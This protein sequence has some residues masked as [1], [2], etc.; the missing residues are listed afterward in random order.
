[1]AI[2]TIRVFAEYTS[3]GYVPMPSQG[4]IDYG[5]T[6][7]STFPETQPS[8]FQTDDPNIDVA[9]TTMTDFYVWIRT[10]GSAWNPNYTRVVRVYPDS[11]SINSVVM[12]MIVAVGG[13]GTTISSGGGV[14]YYLNGGTSQ[15]ILDGST[16]YEMN[17]VPVQGTGVDFFKINTTGFQNIAQFVTDAGDPGLLNIPAGNWPLGLYMSASD[18]SGAPKFYAEIYKYSAAGVFTLLGS[19]VA[20][21]EVISNGQA[22]DYYTSTVAIPETT[23]LV[24]DRIA[25]RIFVNTDGNRTINLHTQDSHLSTV[26]TTF[27]RGLTAI[28]GLIK[29]VQFLAIGNAGSDAAIVSSDDTHTINLPTASATKRG[30]LNSTDWSTFNAKQPALSGDGFVKISGSTISYDNSSYQPLDGDLTAIGALAGT[31]GILKKTGANT[32]EL[33]TSVYLSTATAASTYQRLDKMVSNLLPSDTEYPNSN[34]VLAKLALKA[35][36]ANPSFTGSMNISGAESRVNFYDENAARKY[37]IGYDGGFLRIYQDAGSTSR[38]YINS[39]GKTFIPGTLEVG[40]IIKTGGL[41]TEFLKA[42]GTVDSNT[43]ALNSALANYL[44]SATAGTTYQ[45]LANLSTDLTA[46]TTKYPSVTAVNTG[47][48]TKQPLDAD[49]TAIAALTGTSGLLKKTAADTWTLDTAAYITSSALTNYLLSSDAA[50]TYQRKDKMVSNLLASDTEYPNSN[51]VIAALALKANAANPTFTGDFTIS[52]VTPRLYFVDT[53]NNP[54][55][56]LFTDSGYFY[57]Y[58]QTAGATRFSINSSGYATFNKRVTFQ[59]TVDERPQLPGGF[60]GIDTGD[61]NFD[62]WGISRDYYPSNATAANAWGIRWNGTNND[63]EFVGAGV[64]RAIIDLDN[65]NITSL[66][67]ITASNLSGTNT[68]DQTNIAGYSNELYS[69]DLRTISPSSH[70][71]YRATF[72]FTSWNNNSTGDWADYLHLRSYQDASG[73]ADNLVMFKKNGIAMRIWQQSWGSA[74]AYSSYADVLH[75]SNYSSYALP[76]GGGTMTGQILSPSMTDSVYGGAF[77][78]RERGFVSSAQSAWSYSPAITFHWGNRSVIRMGLRSDGYMAIDDNII[79]TTANVET[80]A[81]LN[82]SRTNWEVGNSVINNVVGQLAWKNY[83]NNHTIFDASNGTSPNGTAVNATNSQVAWSS[84]YPTLMGWNGSNTYGV[85]VDSARVADSSGNS[86]T[87]SQRD[88]SGDIST[89]GQGRFTGWYNGNAATTLGAEIGVSSGRAYVIAYN[90]AA[91]AYGDIQME[92]NYVALKTVNNS[93]VEILTYN[94]YKVNFTGGDQIN[95]Y[96]GSAATTMYLNYSGGNGAGINMAAGRFTLDTAGNAISTGSMRSPIFYDSNDTSYYLDPNSSS[97]A[98]RIAGNIFSDGSFGTNGSSAL[99]TTTVGRTFSPKGGAYSF[100]GGSI[101]GAIKIRLPFRANDAMWSMTVRIYNYSTNQTCEYL[102]GN[103][104]YSQGSWNPSASCY[105]GSSTALQTVRFGN[106]GGYDCVW[107]GET[108]TVWSYPVVSVMDFTSGYSN[109]NV[110]NYMSGWDVNIVSSFGTV[111]GAIGASIKFGDIT[112]TF[113]DSKNGYRSQSNPWGTA[114]SAYFPNGI[115]TAGGTNWI[116]GYTYIGNAPSNGSGHEFFA[117]GN[118][119][120]TGIYTFGL[121]S[122]TDSGIAIN[123]S[124]TGYGRIR[125]YGSGTNYATIHA[126]GTS[127]GYTPSVGCLNI[128]ASGGVTLGGWNDP[129]LSVKSSA[130]T[131]RNKIIVGTFPQSQSNSGEAWLGRAA[132]RSTGIMTVQLGGGSSGSRFE[133]VDWAWSVVLFKAEGNGNVTASGS[134]Y[135]TAFYESSDSRLKTLLQDDIKVKNIE[136]LKAKLYIKNGKK[137]YGYFAQEAQSY[138]PSAVTTNEEGYLNLSYRE[139]HTAKIARLEQRVA[140]LEKQLKLA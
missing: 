9:V 45:T 128:D 11:P 94:N 17:K 98:L 129:Y 115:T 39:S 112:S 81:V 97:T 24:T 79:V 64:N 63:I 57:I 4:N 93:N 7:G 76:L 53:D 140:E 15:G 14:S 65:G 120:T 125:F 87:T 47:L 96:N 86:S 99:S 71:A 113:A 89:G 1:M 10:H 25:I 8:S 130:V 50:T 122:Q 21:P 12:N 48:A 16:Y 73:G 83:G 38:F 67:S 111:A 91:G 32:W 19:S 30:L 42:D 133:V 72:G 78:I 43:Y 6:V 116:Y 26:G 105:G 90:R 134:M 23:L 80:Y 114:D 27:T 41:A 108:S 88:F 58:D 124:N 85:R 139:V 137:E 55:Y 103:Y 3:D 61:S 52:G 29:Q 68:G 102:I 70:N 35:D 132:D 117:N 44:L 22:I 34:A 56:T 66:G 131:F 126:F 104:S 75:S 109:G 138:M 123:H 118:A 74:S 119:S 36:A 101:T 62:I 20:T 100:T 121:G 92:A 54:D 60:L 135:A 2:K 13:G 46:S 59:S 69:K 5:V 82:R 40:T 84:S 107:I 127:S 106:E 33:D 49:L 37:F 110:A 28:N 18:N 31:S 77:Q 95:T 136:N 51:A